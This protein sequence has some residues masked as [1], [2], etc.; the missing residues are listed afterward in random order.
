M[1]HLLRSG[2][3]ATSLALTAGCSGFSPQCTAD[4]DC[5]ATSYCNSA[6][7]AC[8]VRSGGAAI[9]V[10]DAVVEGP[11]AGIV[12]VTGTAPVQSKVSVFTDALCAGT[13]AGTASAD[14][15]GNYSVAATAPASGT[16]YAT[17]E[18]TAVG[19][20]CSLGKTYP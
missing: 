12:T 18:S 11:G 6:A 19:S 5:A 1:R 14:G 16:V 20:T 9:P 10:I 8:F 4:S 2:W 7:Q 13:V 17:A 3:L 15:A